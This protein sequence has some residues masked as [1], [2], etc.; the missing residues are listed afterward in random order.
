MNEI[1]VKAGAYATIAL[2]VV[3]LL[4]WLWPVRQVPTGS[5]G[6]VTV[7]GAIRGVENEGFMIVMPWQSLSVFSIRS[8]TA[9]VENAEGSTSD[10]QP[11]RVSLTVRY[12]VQ[13]DKVAE[14]FEKYSHDGNLQSY[15]QTATQ[16]VVKAVTAKYNAPDLI[17]K[18]EQVSSQII[19]ALRGKLEVYGAQVISVDMRNFA[20]SGEYM[21]AINAKTTQEQLR[22][23]AENKFKTVEAEQKQKVAVAEA[24]ASATRARADGEAY[25]TTKRATAEADA[26]KVQ[27]Q[28]IA[29][30]PMVLELRKIEV[31]L[32]KAHKWKGD[33]PTA[34]YAG[35]PI[36]FLDTGKQFGSPS[37]RQ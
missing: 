11:V 16:E 7:G 5:R 15:V 28:A 10:T 22:L 4:F 33:V 20:F 21:A 9:D 13:P 25:A 14:V 30:N 37:P 18:R 35:A 26:L 19:T 34:V 8:E 31:E 24:E 6:V 36:P 3:V 32:A 29:A 23:G 17:S 27:G 12:S 1:P 2:V